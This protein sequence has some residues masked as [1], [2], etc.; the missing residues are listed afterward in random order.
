[1]HFRG[2]T[3][4]LGEKE[5]KESG[6]EGNSKENINPI[7]A[8]EGARIPGKKKRGKEW[9]SEGDG[10]QQSSTG[11]ERG[12]RAEKGSK[13]RTAETVLTD[14][15]W[16]EPHGGLAPTMGYRRLPQGCLQSASALVLGEDSKH[17]QIPK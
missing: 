7:S 12:Q 4:G 8:L 13:E 6:A 16:M 11:V 1:M 10:R 15:N 5:R 14:E 3:F 2:D 9:G 17:F